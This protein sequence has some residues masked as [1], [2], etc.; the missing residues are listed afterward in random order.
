MRLGPPARNCYSP[1]MC[2][3]FE[4]NVRPRDLAR[5]FGIDDLPT[6]FTTGEVRPT[7]PAL[8]I[9]AEGPRV[10][11]F[12]IDVDW[13]TK[14]L[15]NARAETLTEKPT[16]RPLLESRCLVPASGYFEWRRDG[17]RRLKNRIAP[18]AGGIMAFAGLHQDGRFV[19]VTCA[20][21]ANIQ[22]IH[23]RMPVAL[24]PGGETAWRDPE[25]RYPE[26][27]HLLVAA[28]TTPLGFE[29][30]VPPPPEQPDL[31]SGLV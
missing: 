28:A 2:S 27:A 9:T 31:F 1:A 23:N 11:N 15:I 16:F 19:I 22:H 5:R 17:G 14:P 20:P 4:V 24:T 12:G 21:A 29:E 26:L 3:R 8:V 18:E 6:G 30:E 7:D 13:D 25:R 10:M